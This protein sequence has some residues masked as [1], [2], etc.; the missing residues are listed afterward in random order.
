[1]PDYPQSS[2]FSLCVA[3]TGPIHM[4]FRTSRGHRMVLPPPNFSSC[5]FSKFLVSYPS[6]GSFPAVKSSAA[7]SFLPVCCRLGNQISKCVITACK[8]RVSRL[9]GGAQGPPRS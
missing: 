5:P 7:T 6:R 3:L 9:R 1:M 4:S 8:V 2:H